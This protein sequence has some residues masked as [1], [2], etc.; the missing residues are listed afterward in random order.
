MIGWGGM[1]TTSAGVQIGRREGHLGVV[2]NLVFRGVNRHYPSLGPF[3]S[4]RFYLVL[5][6]LFPQTSLAQLQ[7]GQDKVRQVFNGPADEYQ[8]E[9]EGQGIRKAAGEWWFEDERA[10]QGSKFA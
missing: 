6:P 3:R 1:K 4:H 9:R 10:R 8:A 2:E 5:D 7:E